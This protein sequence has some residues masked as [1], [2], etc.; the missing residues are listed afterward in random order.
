VKT[1]ALPS[2]GAIFGT[3][4]EFVQFVPAPKSVVGVPVLQVNTSG[5]T[6]ARIAAANPNAET[7]VTKHWTLSFMIP[8]SVQIVGS[9]KGKA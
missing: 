7:I 3:A 6:T 9:G 8:D 1:N 5:N 2:E 4:V